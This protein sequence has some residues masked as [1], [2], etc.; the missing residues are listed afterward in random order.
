[1]SLPANVSFFM[2]RIQGI[3]TSHFKINPQTGGNQTS[4]KLVRFELPTNSLVNMKSLRCFFAAVAS[5]GG[6]VSLPADVSSFIERISV[7]MGGVLVGNGHQGYNTLVHA[8]KVL[9][10]DKC[11]TTLGHPEIVRATS[12][13]NGAS[14]SN[15]APETYADNGREHFC[16]DN[17]EGLLG[18][19]E[20]SIIDTGLFPQ[21]TIE[22][23]LADDT[24]CGTSLGRVIGDDVGTALSPTIVANARGTALTF[25]AHGTVAPGYILNEMTMQ[26][27]VLG[28][29]S[30]TLDA[31]VEARIAQV[32]YLSLPFKNYYSYQS[33]HTNTS[34]FNVNSASWDRLWLVYRPTDYT[35]KSAPRVAEGYKKKGCFI[36]TVD[37]FTA[38]GSNKIDIGLPQYDAGGTSFG[39]GEKYISNYF[40]FQ[41]LKTDPTANAFFQLQVNSANIPAYRMTTPETLAMSLNSVDV[42]SKKAMSLKQYTTDH[43]VQCYRFC[44]PESDF[45]RLASGLD[46][47]SV[48]AIGSVT[49]DNIA[50]CSLMMFAEVTSELRVGA[51]RA[52]EVIF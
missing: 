47:R 36:S 27:E 30:N 44:L 45:S 19:L 23:T 21:I 25:D 9:C 39:D 41:E 6:A 42:R 37:T 2:Q 32:G 12:Y 35:T 1:M 26:V 38:D 50:S 11:N 34:R 14:F 40:R 51:S 48:S 17:W 8:K 18:S 20:P 52:I 13:H 5:G 10:G 15:T 49:T 24:V 22:L 16:I 4:G 31:I 7:Y 46:L 3:S 43:F 29:S 33:T 28:F